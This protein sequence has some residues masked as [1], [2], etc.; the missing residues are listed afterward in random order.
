MALG[1]KGRQQASGEATREGVPPS[2]T[3]IEEGQQH[4]EI[5]KPKPVHNWREFFGEIGI[6]VIGVLIAIGAEQTIEALHWQ[7]KAGDAAEA[8]KH[9]MFA[10]YSQAV[11]A[12]SVAPCVD[13]QLVMLEETLGKPGFTSVAAYSDSKFNHYV[14]RAPSRPWADSEWKTAISEGTVTHLP[15]NLRAGLQSAYQ[16]I[17]ILELNTRQADVITWRLRAL[18]LPTTADQR[19]RA[20]ESMEE[21]RGHVGYMALVANQV[22]G[23]L[24]TL[25]M[26]PA[27]SNA[28]EVMR[29][30]GTANFCREHRIAIGRPE[31]EIPS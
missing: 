7:H 23:R 3:P 20:I 27:P 17:G 8:I 21:L 16:Q 31:P 10:N 5:H 13:R 4:V 2:V 25:G 1:D 19:A 26:R 15:E 18:A 12:A 9:E 24:D 14:I 30:S 11:E 22:M 6:I 28:Y 29:T